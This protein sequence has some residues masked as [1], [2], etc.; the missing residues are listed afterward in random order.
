MFTEFDKYNQKKDTPR[1]QQLYRISYESPIFW[2]SMI[3]EKISN[4][5]LNFYYISNNWKSALQK[6]LFQYLYNLLYVPI[7]IFVSSKLKFSHVHSYIVYVFDDIIKC[8]KLI[9]FSVWW[10]VKL[11][12]DILMTETIGTNVL[13]LLTN[14]LCFVSVITSH[15][16]K[17]NI[18]N[19]IVWK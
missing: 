6:P 19:G 15:G 4:Q 14:V 16:I 13:Y 11:N 12:D 5:L 2:S 18:R 1:S 10:L 3:Y 8:V 17:A 7:H 9:I